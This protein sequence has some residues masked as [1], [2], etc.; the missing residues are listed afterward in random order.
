MYSKLTPNSPKALT[1]IQIE[2]EAKN[3]KPGAL[4]CT[5]IS[6]PTRARH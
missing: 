4:T 3:Y 1:Q 6:H 5:A 2:R